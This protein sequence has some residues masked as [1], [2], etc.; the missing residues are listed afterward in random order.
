MLNC[1]LKRAAKRKQ[2]FLG[3]RQAEQRER[4][5]R[6]THQV[7]ARRNANS[8]QHCSNISDQTTIINTHAPLI[9]HETSSC[10]HP[11]QRED[12]LEEH[13]SQPG[14]SYQNMDADGQSVSE[15]AIISLD[16]S[17]TSSTGEE[18]ATQGRNGKKAAS[19]FM[20]PLKNKL[21]GWIPTSV[22]LLLHPTKLRN[23]FSRVKKQFIPVQY[24]KLNQHTLLL[25]APLIMKQLLGLV[26]N[27]YKCLFTFSVIIV[28]KKLMTCYL[29]SLNLKDLPATQERITLA[30]LV[31]VSNLQQPTVKPYSLLPGLLLLP[32]IYSGP[33]FYRQVDACTR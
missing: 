27:R 24:L 26:L 9:F 28:K 21:T 29:K 31:M 17:I 16:S 13:P 7:Q 4:W 19:S 20:G 18:E 15:S 6:L 11:V 33:K 12:S 23:I 3:K 8:T 14:T 30:G 2:A 32:S 1:F 22:K 25:L 10:G 5:A